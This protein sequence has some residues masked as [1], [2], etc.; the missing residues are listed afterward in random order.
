MIHGLV[1]NPFVARIA[2]KEL[3]TASTAQ[4]YFDVLRDEFAELVDKYRCWLAVRFIVE[5]DYF[6]GRTIDVDGGLSM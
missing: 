1:T 2:K 4:C 3:I 6:N 5:C